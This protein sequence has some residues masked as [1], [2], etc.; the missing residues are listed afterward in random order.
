MPHLTA[1]ID[2][3][4]VLKAL[5]ALPAAALAAGPLRAAEGSEAILLT[6]ADLHSPYARLPGILAE[7]RS[8]M[9]AAGGRPAAMILNGDLFERGNVA[10]LRSGASADWAFLRA[11]S[12]ELPVF[13]NLGNHETAIMDDM[14]WVAAAI[15]GAGAQ[16]IG[17]IVDR[18]TGRFFAPVSDRIGLGGIEVAMLGLASNNPFVYRQPARD[19]LTL[20][21]PS[22]FA[23]EV[24]ADATGGADLPVLVSHAGVAADKTILPDLADGTLVLGAHDH[25]DFQHEAGATRYV[26]TGSWGGQLAVIGLTRGADRVET[27][28][29]MRAIAP[30][31][32]DPAI[33]EAIEAA[34]SEHLTETDLAVI[35]ERETALD[36]PASILLAAEAVREATEADIAFLGHTTFGAPLAAGA[37]TRYDFDAFVRFDGDIRVAEVPGETLAKIMIRANQHRAASLDARTGDFV[38]AAE[39]D[40]DPAQTYRVATNGWTAINQTAYLGTEDLEFTPV[41]GAMLKAIVSE[42]LAGEG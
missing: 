16:P 3:R 7:V 18:R 29:E 17:S 32:G 4:L 2:R 37:L 35:A 6:M 40:I 19:T 12:A 25:L 15:T 31:G 42:A 21:D 10:A 23:D 1:A 22:A 33:A 20:L 13:V 39:I 5:A 8:V 41:E 11:L 9:E 38:Y 28:V 14:A 24:F 27:T 34:T 30:G 26:H 36:L